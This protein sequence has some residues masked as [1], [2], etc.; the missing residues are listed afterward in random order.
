MDIC[1]S[2]AYSKFVDVAYKIDVVAKPIYNNEDSSEFLKIG[3][4][5]FHRSA[6]PFE[7]KLI[8]KDGIVQCPFVPK[9]WWW[10]VAYYINM[11][12]E[13]YS[14]SSRQK[15][16]PVE[17]ITKPTIISNKYATIEILT[18]D[19]S[20]VILNGEECREIRVPLDS[21]VNYT[22]SKDGYFSETGEIEATYNILKKVELEEIREQRII[23][24]VPSTGGSVRLTPSR[25]GNSYND[26]TLITVTPVPDAEYKLTKITLSDGTEYTDTFQFTITEDVTITA[27]FEADNTP[28]I[29]GASVTVQGIEVKY[30]FFQ[31]D[32]KLSNI[33]FTSASTTFPEDWEFPYCMFCWIENP[34]AQGLTSLVQYGQSG[35]DYSYRANYSNYEAIEVT[36]KLVDYSQLTRGSSYGQD[37]N[38]TL[39]VTNGSAIVWCHKIS[40]SNPDNTYFTPTGR[41][42]TRLANL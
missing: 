39:E 27:Q 33:D 23:T 5:A 41:F 20:T 37:A 25:E 21:V 9:D 32:S 7:A 6:Y 15:Y 11:G 19:D 29:D 34:L 4:S 18:D 35:T 13:N 10:T 16:A 1:L 26:G 42:W 8:D 36:E 3:G 38:K 14:L 40:A 24:V 30:A 31:C 17:L 28:W 2:P 12:N 22:V